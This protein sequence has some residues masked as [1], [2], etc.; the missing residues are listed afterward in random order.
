VP[1]RAKPRPADW[2]DRFWLAYPCRKNVP[3]IEQ[4]LNELAATKTIAFE[5]VETAAKKYRIELVD[6]PN[7]VL[8][9]GRYR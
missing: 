6:L 7:G 2:R 4:A 3:E 9:D 8:Y 1:A 5:T